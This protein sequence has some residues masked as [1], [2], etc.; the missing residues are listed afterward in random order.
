MTSLPNHGKQ[1]D[2]LQHQHH[3]HHH[4]QLPQ[5]MQTTHKVKRVT[6]GE[7]D[8]SGK[9][10]GKC[11]HRRTTNDKKNTNERFRHLVSSSGR[12]RKTDNNKTKKEAEK[13]TDE[14]EATKLDP[15][16][17][18]CVCIAEVSLVRLCCDDRTA[19]I[20]F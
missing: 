2:S 4:H 6:A 20:C 16:L 14:K 11:T 8:T 15:S 10:L 9:E 1:G 19:V 12:R 3:H 18:I 17:S 13:R 7:V 5:T